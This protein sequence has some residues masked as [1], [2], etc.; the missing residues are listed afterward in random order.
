MLNHLRTVRKPLLTNLSSSPKVPVTQRFHCILHNTLGDCVC[1]VYTHHRPC[2]CFYPR[3][4]GNETTDQSNGQVE[5]DVVYCRDQFLPENETIMSSH[6]VYI[7]TYC[8]CTYV[9]VN[10]CTY[11]IMPYTNT[12]FKHRKKRTDNRRQTRDNAHPM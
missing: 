3:H 8:I 1:V 4:K 11:H 5:V 9:T 2:S 10:V 12:Y 7:C 6:C